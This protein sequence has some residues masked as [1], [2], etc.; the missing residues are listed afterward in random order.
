MLLKCIKLMCA[1]FL[2][3]TLTS[4]TTKVISSSVKN[5]MTMNQSIQVL[6]LSS[7]PVAISNNAVAQVQVNNATYLYSF[8]GLE[9]G[10]DWQDVSKKAFRYSQGR[11]TQLS[12]VPVPQGRLASIAVTV[13]NQIYLF[14]GYTVAEDHSEVST[15][16]VLRF[17]PSTEDYQRVA[18]IPIPS[19]DATAF[20]YQNRYIYL[21]SGWHD[22][23]NINLVQVYDVELDEWK[24]A[25]QFPGSPVFGHAGGMLGNELLVCDGVK[26]KYPNISEG[27]EARRQFLMS[28]ECY[29]GRVDD[30]DVTRIHW[31]NM[32]KHFGP[33][34]YRMASTEDAARGQIIFV[35]GSDNPYNF[36]GIG[37]DGVAS[38]P[39]TSVFAFDLNSKQWVDY[40]VIDAPTMDHRGMLKLDNGF[41]VVGGMDNNQ[42]VLTK[43]YQISLKSLKK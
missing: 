24:Q 17:D 21:V 37:Y 28:D 12:D 38:K 10:K 2:A 31:A 33:A 42:E 40:G 9:S 13:R 3:I 34:R 8:L 26:I 25:T 30:N 20:V 43:A 23:G 22:R 19:D 7:L 29:L 1:L 6:E 35:G 16:E 39:V 36:N 5:Q 32:P 4:C 15:P 14:G 27:T 11:W 18:D 41:V